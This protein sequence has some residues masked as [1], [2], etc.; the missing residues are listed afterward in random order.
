LLT[1]G[2]HTRLILESKDKMRQRGVPSPDEWDAVALTFA[3]P[4]ASD[5]GFGRKLTYP[6]AAVT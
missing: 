5:A 6:N 3:E 2:E 1:F 4:V